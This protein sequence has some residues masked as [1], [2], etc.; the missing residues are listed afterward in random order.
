MN[1]RLWAS[2]VVAGRAKRLFVG[3]DSDY[4]DRCREVGKRLGPFDL[5]A[6]SIGAYKPALI[7]KAVH[8]TSEEAVQVCSQMSRPR[9]YALR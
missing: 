7:M 3:G 4:F 6:V 9:R 8:T 1:S 5:S 2:W